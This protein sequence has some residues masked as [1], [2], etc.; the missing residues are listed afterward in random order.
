MRRAQIERDKA[1]AAIARVRALALSPHVVPIQTI[2]GVENAPVVWPHA[3][4]N[5]L[6]QGGT[7]A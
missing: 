7:D 2:E 3:I 1:Q 6:D 4:L 5:A